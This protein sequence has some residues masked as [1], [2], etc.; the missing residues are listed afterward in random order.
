MFQKT[1]GVSAIALTLLLTGCGGEEVVLDEMGNPVYTEDSSVSTGIS[2][3]LQYHI[4]TAA[5]SLRSAFATEGTILAQ[6][7]ESVKFAQM[8]LPQ[9][10]LIATEDGQTEIAAKLTALDAE[11][12]QALSLTDL[13]AFTS[14][15]NSIADQLDALLK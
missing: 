12:T 13:T 1:L 4:E 9:A 5:S 14:S 11:V 15:I 7:Q 8:T 3:A 6:A 10:A 2:S